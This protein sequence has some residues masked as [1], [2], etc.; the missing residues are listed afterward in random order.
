MKRTPSFIERN[1]YTSVLIVF[2]ALFAPLM[3]REWISLRAEGMYNVEWHTTS[4]ATLLQKDLGGLKSLPEILADFGN[5]DTFADFDQH[6]RMKLG[7]LGLLD[8][9]I[10]NAAGEVVYAIDKGLTGK[11]ILAGAE[12]K[13]AFGG[14]IASRLVDQ[15]EYFREYSRE[16]GLDLAEVY[17][18][19]ENEDGKVPYVLEAYY[20]YAPITHR[21][22]AL[23]LKSAASLLITILAVLILLIYLYRSRQKMSRQVEALEAIL[24]ICMHCKK[25]R[26][27]NSE[28]DTTRW[29]DMESYFAEQGDLEFSHGLCE[30]CLRKHYPD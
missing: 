20:D 25:I 3:A 16:P 12:R 22:H 27:E 28:D 26:V 21:T 19:V 15:E 4:M 1:F 7:H 30:D 14:K 6:V 23:L 18:P 5:E 29:L 11:V 17:V 9:K 24:P 10:Y 13:A 2:L 8:V